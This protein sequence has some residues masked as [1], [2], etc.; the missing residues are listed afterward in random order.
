MNYYFNS[1]EDNSNLD[2]FQPLFIFFVDFVKDLYPYLRRIESR[3]GIQ[4]DKNLKRYL[5]LEKIPRG[6]HSDSRSTNIYK[7][8]GWVK[9]KSTSNSDSDIE[10]YID[11]YRSIGVPNKSIN[12]L[13]ALSEKYREWKIVNFRSEAR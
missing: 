2:N 13:V 11:H 6:H 4:F 1:T 3:Y 10:S 8:I 12:M 7:K 5:K 9:L